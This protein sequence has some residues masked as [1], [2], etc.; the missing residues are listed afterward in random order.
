MKPID[1]GKAYDQITDLW[2][3]EDFNQENGIAQHKRA[4]AF[5]DSRGKAL[6]VGCGCNGRLIDLILTEGFEVEG[7]D[8]SSEMIKHARKRHPQVRFQHADIVTLELNQS[9]DFITAWDSIWHLPLQDHA[10]VLLKL[11]TALKPGGICI[12]SAGGLDQPEEKTDDFMGPEVGYSTLGVPGFLQVISEAN[13]ICRH[14][15]YDQYPEVH[16]YFIVQKPE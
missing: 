8:I 9:Y 10:R 3:R 2:L 6:D 15:E 11:F 1:I 5:T 12:F 13:C 16:I 14:L 4:L 7:V